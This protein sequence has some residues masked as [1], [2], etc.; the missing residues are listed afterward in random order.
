MGTIYDTIGV[1]NR[2]KTKQNSYKYYTF[3]TSD[4]SCS[5]TVLAR[6]DTTSK[7]KGDDEAV[8]YPSVVFNGSGK[9]FHL[10]V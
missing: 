6:V 5:V 4:K 7:G 10:A 2:L 8:R 1:L 3:F 9:L